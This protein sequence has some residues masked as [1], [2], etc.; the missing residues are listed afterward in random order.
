MSIAPTPVKTNSKPVVFAPSPQPILSGG[1]ETWSKA[2]LV[3][4][5]AALESTQ[6]LTPQASTK[7]PKVLIDG[8]MRLARYPWWPASGQ[9]ADAWLYYDG[10][11]AVW[12][13]AGMTL[14]T[15]T[16]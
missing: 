13:N 9:T 4:I 14:P 5:A 16:H 2:Q 1:A 8:M 7:A 6:S 10:A 11:G 12:L 15:S 3:A